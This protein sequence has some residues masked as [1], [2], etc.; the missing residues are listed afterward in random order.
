MEGLRPQR[1]ASNATYSALNNIRL[2]K[3]QHDGTLDSFYHIV[4]PTLQDR[5]RNV[6]C[7]AASVLAARRRFMDMLQASSAESN[8]DTLSR[9]AEF[10][11]P[12]RLGSDLLPSSTSECSTQS[13]IPHGSDCHHIESPVST[14]A[15]KTLEEI[16]A[17]VPKIRADAAEAS[18]SGALAPVLCAIGSQLRDVMTKLAVSAVNPTALRLQGHQNISQRHRHEHI[19]SSDASEDA[20]S[21]T[22]DSVDYLSAIL[23]NTYLCQWLQ[24]GQQSST[25]FQ[26]TVRTCEGLAVNFL[27]DH[28]ASAEVV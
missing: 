24:L 18:T 4:H 19:S 3:V 8:S 2:E 5:V 21:E 13:G 26:R 20:L 9:Q 7:T 12:S 25:D 28:G 27:Y 23:A 10:A 17:A 1:P 22:G 14:C 16:K 15:L 11:P 6:V